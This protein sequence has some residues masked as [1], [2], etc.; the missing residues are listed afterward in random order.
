MDA[1]EPDIDELIAEYL[2]NGLDPERL[3]QL[4]AWAARSEENRRY[5][6]QREEVWFSAMADDEA[7]RY[8]EAKA[9]EAFRRRVR[10]AQ[11][12]ERGKTARRAWI[13]FCR[14]AAAV[15]VLCVVAYFSYRKGGSDLQ[16]A[17]AQIAVEAPEGSQTRMF[18]PDSTL[19]VLNAGSRLVYAQDFGVDNREV[20]LEGEG[21]FEVTH[22]ADR[23]FRVVS[24]NVAL[25]VLGTKFDF[26]DY[27]DE[28][29]VVV[30]L[31]EGRVSLNNRIRRETDLALMPNERMVMNKENGL[32]KR[33]RLSSDDYLKWVDGKL[34]FNGEPLAQVAEILQRSYGVSIVISTES[35]KPLP[36]F[37]RF[38]RKEQGLKEILDIMQATGKIRYGMIKNKVIIY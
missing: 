20:Q 31:R 4:Q 16:E 19:V 28:D 15:A 8:D 32:M 25:T 6:M 14:C 23:P 12:A 3:R 29:E 24:A 2:S 33:E 7:G 37:G 36:F 1:N 5:L 26:R 13:T 34:V 35:L 22:R 27:A 38:D 30:S 17:L 10:A 9:F 21:Y 11:K 18:L